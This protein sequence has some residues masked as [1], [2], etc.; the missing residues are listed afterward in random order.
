MDGFSSNVTLSHIRSSQNKSHGIFIEEG[1]NRVSLTNSVACNN[2]HIG[3]S[4]NQQL[5]TAGILEQVTVVGC[6][7]SEN[8]D[9]GIAVM[10]NQDATHVRDIVVAD[11]ICMNNG[12]DSPWTKAGIIVGKYQGGTAKIE[13]VIVKGNRCGD[14]QENKTQKFGIYLIEGVEGV[15]A[16][17]NN[18]RGNSINGLQDDGAIF[19][20]IED[21]LE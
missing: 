17:D 7:A 19:S 10:A 3:I 13:N 2:G 15:V 8:N 21:N 6:V 14:N 11:N 4:L 9:Q 12:Q 16:V 5:A 18:V 20:L 1:S